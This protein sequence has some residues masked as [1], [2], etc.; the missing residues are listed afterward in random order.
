MCIACEFHFSMSVLQYT[1]TYEE[2]KYQMKQGMIHNK[3][4]IPGTTIILS[5][6]IRLLSIYIHQKRPF[7]IVLNINGLKWNLKYGKRNLGIS[8][9]IVFLF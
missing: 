1:W 8:V 9:P 5:T 6:K 3:H 7:V 4:Q 2:Y